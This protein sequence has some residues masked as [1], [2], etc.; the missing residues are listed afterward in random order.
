[1]MLSIREIFYRLQIYPWKKIV[2]NYD[3]VAYHRIERILK[4]PLSNERKI[5][6]HEANQYSINENE[7]LSLIQEDNPFAIGSQWEMLLQKI[8][9]SMDPFTTINDVY[10]H[11]MGFLPQDPAAL[12]KLQK[13]V[14][15]L[16]NYYQNNKMIFLHF[17]HLTVIIAKKLSGSDIKTKSVMDKKQLISKVSL[18]FSPT[19]QK[20]EAFKSV[21]KSYTTYL[22][23]KYAHKAFN[24]SI[25]IDIACLVRLA[26]S[27]VAA[28]DITLL[29][30]TRYYNKVCEILKNLDA[31]L[32]K[33][34]KIKNITTLYWNIFSKNHNILNFFKNKL[35]FKKL[36]KFLINLKKIEI[37][38]L[39]LP[40]YFKLRRKNITIANP[41][42]IEFKQHPCFPIE[43]QH[44]FGDGACH[45]KR[46]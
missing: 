40:T 21:I 9:A 42:R 23:L 8:I 16:M 17:S 15:C 25:E 36:E 20:Y 43:S 14:D 11:L 5:F 44:I 7:I 26:K 3:W 32:Q 6:I 18:G 27:E 38:K 12:Q 10:N 37:Q 1:M 39:D 45:K 29:A 31:L 46:P 2:Q 35:S 28:Q 34:D 22:Q 13:N 30:F 19:H 41:G 24:E 33:T 4:N